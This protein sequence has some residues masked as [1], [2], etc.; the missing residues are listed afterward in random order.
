MVHIDLICP[1]TKMVQQRQPGDEIKEVGLHLICMTF[2][3]PCTGKFERSQAPY[4][5]IKEIKIDNKEYIDKTSAR[6]S[7][8]F[9][10]TWL[11]RCPT[12]NQVLVYNGLEFIKNFLPLLKGFDTTLVLTSIKNT[13]ST[14]LVERVNQVLYHVFITKDISNRLFDYIGQ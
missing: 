14:A 6:I 7:Q 9:N 11:L 2:T 1:Y 8:L 5:D 13:Q 4:F 10:N 12:P 3:N